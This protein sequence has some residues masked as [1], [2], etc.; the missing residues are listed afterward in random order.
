M[1]GPNSSRS[2]SRSASR[3]RTHSDYGR[4]E[5]CPLV[6]DEGPS[7]GREPSHMPRDDNASGDAGASNYTAPRLAR[8]VIA[9]SLNIPDDLRGQVMVSPFQGSDRLGAQELDV[10]S[11]VWA[12]LLR[13]RVH[14]H[15]EFALR[16]VALRHGGQPRIAAS[17][18]HHDR[19]GHRYGE[20]GARH[21]AHL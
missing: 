1:S 11:D 7:E 3:S 10:A 13:D 6:H 17:G 15:S 12:G 20:D 8:E 2:A 21:S 19:L 5:S 18:R 9:Q 14:G 4:G 16:P